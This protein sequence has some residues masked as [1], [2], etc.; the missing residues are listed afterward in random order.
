MPQNGQKAFLVF[1]AGR[2]VAT[3]SYHDNAIYYIRER[4]AGN[5]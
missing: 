4:F 5:D 2:Q 3:F 1:F